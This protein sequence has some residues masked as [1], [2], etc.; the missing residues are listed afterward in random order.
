MRGECLRMSE[1][2][3]LD[4]PH[5]DLHHDYYPSSVYKTK[6][7]KEFRQL[8]INKEQLCRCIHNAIHAMERPPEKPPISYMRQVIEAYYRG[9]YE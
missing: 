2:C 3:P 6:V 1:Q 8:P 9:D 7:E 5:S 4:K